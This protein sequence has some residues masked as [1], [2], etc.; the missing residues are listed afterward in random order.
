M[1][2]FEFQGVECMEIGSI[3][4]IREKFISKEGLKE[5]RI[6]ILIY[7]DETMIARDK[8]VDYEFLYT[9]EIKGKK[10]DIYK[11][12]EKNGDIKYLVS[13]YQDNKKY[14]VSGNEDVEFLEAISEEYMDLIF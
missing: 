10:Q 2:D 1:S 8:F 3:H 9:N 5:I 14:F 7:I 12:V 13:F 11:K 4:E 6:G